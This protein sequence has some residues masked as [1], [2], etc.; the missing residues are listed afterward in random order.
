MGRYA[1]DLSV[2]YVH[3][4]SARARAPRLIAGSM[5]MRSLS[6]APPSL[7][8]SRFVAVLG[9]LLQTI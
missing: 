2:G 6:A 7:R 9:H 4:A 3:D 5:Q 8:G 1:I